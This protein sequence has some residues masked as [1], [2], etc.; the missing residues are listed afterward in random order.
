MVS[1]RSALLALAALGLPEFAVAQRLPRVGYLFSFTRPEGEHLWA[2][3]Q[4]GLRDYG[5]VQGK[6]IV[7]EPRWAEGHHARLPALV[8]DLVNSRVEVIVAAATPASRMATMRSAVAT[9]RRM[10]IRD[11]FTAAPCP[12]GAS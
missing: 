12:R 7:L 8:S 11:G 10:K 2:A 1:R 6:N 9:G 5:Y 3:C 4:E